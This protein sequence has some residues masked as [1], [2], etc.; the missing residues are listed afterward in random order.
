M[1][2]PPARLRAAM[3]RRDMVP[4]IGI[5][6]VFSATLAARHYDGL[7]LSGFS[8]AAS[9]YGLPD[10]G[11]IAW[12]DVVDLARRIRAVL[13]EPH[14]VVD[15]DDGYVD[16]DVAAHVTRLLEDAGASAV[17]LEDQARPRRC[18][19]FLGKRILEI[20]GYIE[21]LRRVLDARRKDI[22]VIAR[23]DACDD[24]ERV[25]R[26]RAFAEAGADAVLADGLTGFDSI[27]AIAA[28][29]RVPVMFN[30]IAGGL[31]PR[32]TLAELRELGVTLVNYSTPC[33][34][35]AQEAIDRSL[36][37]LKAA[38]GLLPD[39][40]RDGHV[41]V[42]ACTA[43]MMENMRRQ[44]GDV[45]APPGSTADAPPK[46]D[47]PQT[48]QRP[49]APQSAAHEPLIER[50]GSL[51]P[52]QRRNLRD[53]LSDRPG[54]RGLI[55]SRTPDAPSPASFAQAR[56]WFLDRLYPGDKSYV[57]VSHLH[58]TGTLDR[59]RFRRAL[60]GVIQRQ[61]SLRTAII[62]DGDGNPRLSV[63]PRLQFDIAY[64]DLAALPAERQETELERIASE[65]CDQSYALDRAPLWR[66]SLVR[67]ADDRHTLVWVIHHIVFDLWSRDRLAD[68]LA[69]AYDRIPTGEDPPPLAVSYSDFAAWQHREFSQES[70]RSRLEPWLDMLA[71]PPPPLD[72]PFARPRPP[73]QT[74]AGATV[75]DSHPAELLRA[76]QSLASSHATTR[77]TVFL[78]ALGLLLRHCTG[79]D[80]IVIGVPVAGRTATD[81][82]PIIG[83]FVNTLAI[84]V[85]LDGDPTFDELLARVRQNM[86]RALRYQD[87]PFDRVV[88]ALNL[89]RDRSRQPL[90][91]VVLNSHLRSAPRSAASRTLSILSDSRSNHAAQFDLSIILEPEGDG[92]GLDFKYNTDLFDQRPIVEFASAYRRVLRAVTRASAS[93][94]STILSALNQ[95]EPSPAPVPTPP[96]QAVADDACLHRWFEARA[97]RT[98]DATAV[99]SETHRLSYQQLDERADDLALRL[100]ELD[101]RPDQPVGLYMTRS[102]EMVVAML[103]ILKAGGAWLPLDPGYP[104][105]RLAFS[106]RDAGLRVVLAQT[107][108]AASVPG[109]P[110]HVLGI[111]ADGRCERSIRSEADPAC[112]R[113][114]P[115]PPPHSDDR[116]LAYI[117]Y[118]SGSTGRPKGVAIEHRA[119]VNHMRW[120]A[121][122]F[123][124]TPDDRVLQKTPIGFDAS[125]WEFWAPLLSGATL[126]MAGP[127]AHR[128]PVELLRCIQRHRVTIL[129]L[130]PTMLGAVLDHPTLAGAATL[131]RVFVGGEALG[132]A[133]AR[134]FFEQSSA[135]LVNLYGPTEAAIDATY[136]VCDREPQ[137]GTV[138][139]GRPIDGMKAY[140]LDDNLQPVPTGEI[141][142]L[143][144]AGLGLAR[145]YLN[146]PE[147]TR[148]KFLPDPRSADPEARLYRTGDRVRQRPDGTLEY[149]GRSDGQVKLRG[150]R[151]EMGE[152]ESLLCESPG[153]AAAAVILRTD[154][155]DDPR[156]AAFV[157][158]RPGGRIDPET[159]RSRLG[160]MLPAPAVPS[161][162]TVLDTMPR[163]PSGKIDRAALTGLAAPSASPPLDPT[164]PTTDHGNQGDPDDVIAEVWRQ[165]LDVTHARPEDDFF[166]SGGHSLLAMRL[167]ARIKSRTGADLPVAALFE[168]PTLAGLIA[169][170][171][172]ALQRPRAES[173]PAQAIP[174]IPRSQRP[175]THGS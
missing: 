21:K 86:L 35:A 56:L 125:V 140:V 155:P 174:R 97:R 8:F 156:L 162:F 48:V 104:A 5:Y 76:V 80:D 100:R 66:C 172:E 27:R 12:S 121:H 73:I 126:V 159:L 91:S 47:G 154:R 149:L 145:G 44:L 106:V 74:F 131:R 130:V 117:I 65:L 147:L 32:C 54:A 93:P 169:A 22:V 139:I 99:L 23:T 92:L 64:L 15:I 1:T 14:L 173:E 67:T 7:F 58:I 26:V 164:E 110:S 34:F 129:Q 171:T 118:T 115:A 46:P 87:A 133:T 137:G 170:V 83:L 158:P 40:H 55:P 142:E 72:L 82:E 45:P 167:I 114:A 18:G 102:V 17:V 157:T 151:I 134:R 71:D 146:S 85:R 41:G 51:S 165:T 78:A 124:L 50:L 53:R 150:H 116:R 175:P 2:T 98:P 37:D 16:P 62:D 79:R 59:D 29:V 4:M 24:A 3:S 33:L 132:V 128:D 94:I 28:A 20:D 95:P 166:V 148:Q 75:R 88:H 69:D 136:H 127:E 138:P 57:S 108:I 153:V 49:P 96:R 141:G 19:H 160:V 42:K 111:D 168:R 61:E 38:D 31:S 112:D 135:E 122:R 120:M 101:V 63:E 25:R 81:L 6:D 107:A 123:P 11:F 113:S 70:L 39:I 30:Q 105:D 36:K 161:S 77:F 52:R 163:L 109:S 152:I 68:E 103:A 84:R 143:C 13:P 119:I 90:F 10:I 60:E 43:L 89:P 9:Y 144:L